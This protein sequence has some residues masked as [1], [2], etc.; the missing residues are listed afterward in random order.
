MAAA[1]MSLGTS[2]LARNLSRL[3]LAVSIA[4]IALLLG[5]FLARLGAVEAAAERAVLRAQYQ[6]M[7][8]RLMTWRT[9]RMMRGAGA[10]PATLDELARHLG[11]GELTVVEHA[12]EIDWSS[13]APGA[14]VY[15][16]ETA[17]FHYRVG[18]RE[19][20]LVGPD[21]PPRVRFRLVPS[22]ADT[23][24]NRRYDPPGE[25]LYGADLHLLDRAALAPP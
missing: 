4:I 6:D 24:G 2:S 23:N 8:A 11:R 19:R 12:N 13:V 9:E 15:V 5:L 10:A 3:E 21:E 16:R 14:W 20:L 25:T 17:E 18:H 7:Q 22:Y 1:A